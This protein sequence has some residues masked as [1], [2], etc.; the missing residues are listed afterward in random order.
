MPLQTLTLK[1]DDITAADY[2]AWCRDPDPPALDC[3]L[4]S[5]RLKADPLGDTITAILDWNQP[6]PS[7]RTAAALAGL[8]LPPGAHLNASPTDTARTHKPSRPG[9]CHGP[10]RVHVYERARA[11]AQPPGSAHESSRDTYVS[12]ELAL[13]FADLGGATFALAHH[14]ALNDARIAPRV[15]RIHDLFV[16]LNPVDRPSRIGRRN[17]QAVITMA[18]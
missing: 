4:S 18:A 8:P 12:H 6:A 9:H 17:R 1:L 16:Q 5:I 15:Q 10:K 13:A 2:L 3:G 14:G 11:S 7:P